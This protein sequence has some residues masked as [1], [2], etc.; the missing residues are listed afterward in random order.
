MYVCMHVCVVENYHSVHFIPVISILYIRMYV[1]H[2]FIHSSTG[3]LSL[4]HHISECQSVGRQDARVA[5]N[6]HCGHTQTS[7]N[8]T[9]MLTSCS[10]KTRQGVTRRVIPFTL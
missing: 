5:V 4:M 10:T 3:L 2:T 1:S 7:G 8:G 6:K 9:G